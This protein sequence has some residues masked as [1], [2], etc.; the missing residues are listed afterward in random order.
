MQSKSLVLLRDF[1]QNVKTNDTFIDT[2]RG[3]L[4]LELVMPRQPRGAFHRPCIPPQDICSKRKVRLNVLY[5][6]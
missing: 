5:G 3:E 6:F 4:R 1:N 2:L